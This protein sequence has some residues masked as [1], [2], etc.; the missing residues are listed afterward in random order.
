MKNNLKVRFIYF[1]LSFHHTL[2]PDHSDFILTKEF[3]DSWNF[4][5]SSKFFF[6]CGVIYEIKMNYKKKNKK[7]R[8]IYIACI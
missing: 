3:K 7:K 6:G 4:Q 5:F 1:K 8:R 2:S